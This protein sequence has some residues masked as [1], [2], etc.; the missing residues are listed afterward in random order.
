MLRDQA[1]GRVASNGVSSKS[2]SPADF[3]GGNMGWDTNELDTRYEDK[4]RTE[5]RSEPEVEDDDDD[6]SDSGQDS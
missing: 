2:K 3:K 1:G 6:E 5:R 4:L